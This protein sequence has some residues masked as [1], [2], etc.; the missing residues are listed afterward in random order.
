MRHVRLALVLLASLLLA[1]CVRQGGAT[2]SG[3][4]ADIPGVGST[5]VD[6]PRPTGPASAPCDEDPLPPGSDDTVAERVAALRAIGLFADRETLSEAELASDVEAGMAVTFG[7]A[8][9]V[10]P[11]ILDLAAAEQDRARV[12]WRDLEADV[13]EGNDV[14]VQTLEEWADISVNAFAPTDIV[15]SWDGSEGPVTIAFTDGG[16]THELSPVFLED[17]IDVG[18]LVRINELIAD[19]GRR[20]ELYKAFDQTALVM[21]LTDAE[22]Q[23]LEARGWCFE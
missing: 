17:W 22:R 7:A 3:D 13:I 1:S 11:G 6:V 16:T 21:A 8:E 20:F 19:S 4:F 23:A 10:P 2:G 18:I 9:D 5:R 12:W 14:Y 15:E